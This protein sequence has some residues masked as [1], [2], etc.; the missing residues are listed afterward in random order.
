MPKELF[1]LD[2][3]AAYKRHLTPDEIDLLFRQHLLEVELVQVEQIALL[4]CLI[5]HHGLK[6]VFAEGFSPA[7]AEAYREKIAVLR[8]MEMEEIPELR[9]QLADVR[10]GMAGSSEDRKVKREEIE[11]QIVALLDDHK[12]RM[13][14][15]V[16]PDVC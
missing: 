4:R 9:R 12:H 10:K 15:M 7:E 3:K 1:A 16:L 8:S 6:R 5:K 11:S 2:M 13:I 14:E